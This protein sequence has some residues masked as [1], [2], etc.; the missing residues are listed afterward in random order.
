M[1]K[2]DEIKRKLGEATDRY[3]RAVAEG[4]KEEA[5]QAA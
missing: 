4:K 2:I 5:S 1:T 3:D